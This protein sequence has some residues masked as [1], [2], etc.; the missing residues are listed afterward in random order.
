MD[1]RPTS[2]IVTM[3]QLQAATGYTRAADIRR[4]LE[5]QGIQVRTGRAGRVWTTLTAIEGRQIA[6]AAPK[7]EFA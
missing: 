7:I 4:C 1:A 5:R 6:P 3:E 2:P